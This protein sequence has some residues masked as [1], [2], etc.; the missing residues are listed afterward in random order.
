MNA[1]QS[2][3]HRQSATAANRTGNDIPASIA[4]L[5]AY[6]PAR[7]SCTA[8][9]D[10]P[11][12]ETAARTRSTYS[13]LGVHWCAFSLLDNFTAPLPLPSPDSTSPPRQWMNT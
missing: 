1:V 10:V 2:L 8:K 5:A 7:I 13:P 4:A 9:S 3:C 11:T 12:V 6:I